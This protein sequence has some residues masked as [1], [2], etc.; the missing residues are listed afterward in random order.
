MKKGIKK[1]KLKPFKPFKAYKLWFY[2]SNH[3]CP[4]SFDYLFRSYSGFYS[5]NRAISLMNGPVENRVLPMPQQVW[6]S[7]ESTGFAM[8]G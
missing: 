3:M 4:F 7:I 8:S 1:K 2:K 5:T 6:R